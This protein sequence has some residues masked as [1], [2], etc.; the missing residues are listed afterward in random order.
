MRN[1]GRRTPKS[2]NQRASEPKCLKPD[3]EEPHSDPHC[4]HEV[5][6]LISEERRWPRPHDVPAFCAGPVGA[7]LVCCSREPERGK[8]KMENTDADGIIYEG[9]RGGCLARTLSES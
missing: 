5:D 2:R 9:R 4:P 3:R 6:S 1:E 7:A 8:S